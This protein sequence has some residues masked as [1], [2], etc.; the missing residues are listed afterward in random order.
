MLKT[1]LF[2]LLPRRNRA[3][4]RFCKRYVNQ[5]R[6]END[7]DMQ[8]NGELAFLRKALP[9]CRLVFDIGANVG[10]WAQLALDI[11]PGLG[12]HCFEPSRRTY[13]QLIANAFPPN[14]VC[15]HFGL[16]SAA[17]EAR[18]LLFGDGSGM[19][20]LYPRQGLEAGWGVDANAGEEV[21]RLDSLDNYVERLGIGSRID[22]CK[23]DV[24][25][26]ELEVLKGM[27]SALSRRQI[28]AIQFEYGGC[29]IDARV[30]LKDLFGFLQPRGYAMFKIYP[31]EL[32]AVQRYDQRLEN[33]Q[34]QNWV[35][36]P[37][38]SSPADLATTVPSLA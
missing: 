13:E 23:I 3:L 34:Y 28:G 35:A 29:N 25:G 7:V 31:R 14:V 2:G 8:S 11:H 15:N 22:L 4:Y 24:E 10:H 37:N 32:R 33:F 5:Y 16:G 36:I 1:Q 19:N 9:D 6:G 18:L 38:E 20:S 26:H 12:V 27:T 21:I 30:L 17:G